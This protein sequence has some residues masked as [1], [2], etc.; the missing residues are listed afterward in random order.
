MIIFIYPLTKTFAMKPFA[1]SK[2]EHVFFSV[3]SVLIVVL[4]IAGFSNTYLPKVAGN[5]VQLPRIL[6][7]H[8]LVFFIW[9]MF[10]VF[11]TT[12]IL[13]G[14]V[15]LHRRLGNWG[16]VFAFLMLLTGFAVAIDAARS[17]HLGIPGVM[18]PDTDGFLLLNIVAILVFFTLTVLG[19]LYRNNP[20]AHKRLM[21]MANV[22]GLLGPGVSRLPFIMG[23]VPAV[24]GLIFV[25][26]LAGPVYDFIRFRKIHPAYIPGILLSL[27]NLP[28]VVG[29]LS[30]T[31]LWHSIAGWLTGV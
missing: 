20:Q 26:L 8:A 25:F 12:S 4:I 17:G 2:N 21:L 11:Q 29:A 1:S 7:I 10:F 5:T 28:P 3:M 15:A 18:F 19:W 16:L 27:L 23:I 31:A 9:I 6:H 30:S 14:K 22:G 24:A 13:R